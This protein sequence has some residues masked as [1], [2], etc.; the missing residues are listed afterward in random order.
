MATPIVIVDSTT[1]VNAAAANLFML[2]DGT[3]L[4]VKQWWGRVRYNG[5]ALVVEPTISHASDLDTGSLSF[6]SGN[7][8]VDITLSGFTN[9]PSIQLTAHG[10]TAYYPKVLAL[11]NVLLTVGFFDIDTGAKIATGSLDTDMDFHVQMTGD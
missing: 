9:P 2:A 5:S 8:E 1:E 6:D 10:A 11:T 3:T 7:T 4:N